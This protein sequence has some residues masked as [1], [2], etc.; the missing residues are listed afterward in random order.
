[1]DTENFP[2]VAV[3]VVVPAARAVVKPLL[4]IVATDVLT[5]SQVTCVVISGLVLSEYV[6]V[7]VSC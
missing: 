1:M 2:E 7:A 6:P 4:T 5:E 3:M